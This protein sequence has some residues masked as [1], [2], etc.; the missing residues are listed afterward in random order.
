QYDLAL[1]GGDDRPAP[2][3][4]FVAPNLAAAQSSFGG[5]S[6]D[7]FI[8]WVAVHELTHAV[9][10][11]AVD[12]LRPYL[13]G[14][15]SQLLASLE[16]S[17]GVRRRPVK[18]LAR[19]FVDRAGRGVATRDPMAVMLS[20]EDHQLVGQMQAA[21]TVVEGHAEHVMDAAGAAAIPSLPQLRAAMIERRQAPGPLWRILGKVLGME[22]KMRQYEMGRVFCN[23]VVREAGVVGLNRVWESPE[24]LPSLAEI[25]EP[26]LW[27]ER[28]GA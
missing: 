2:R 22:M 18:D 20:R 27:L 7:D 11:G 14:I 15:A 4:L 1:V 6:D 28:I 8:R 12:W 10:F 25:A 26:Q 21:M 19:D 16:S 17:S 13:G 9:Q 23:Q 24:A 3:L 5:A